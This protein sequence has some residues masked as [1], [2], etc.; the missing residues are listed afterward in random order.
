MTTA[1]I[2]ELE[3]KYLAP[4]YS[5]PPIVLDRGEGAYLYDLEGKRYL[6]FIGGIAVNSLGHSVPEIIAAVAQQTAKLMHV[7]NLYH[8]A[9]HAKLAKLLVD[10]AFPSRVFFC[11][12]GSETIE[13]ALKFSR[14]WANSVGGDAK[15]EIVSFEHSFHG[16]TYGAISATAQPKYHEGF[17]PMLPGMVY[18][19]FNDTAA[20]DAA[21]SEERTAAVVIEPVQGEGGV[22]AAQAEFLRTLRNL[23]DE[24][25]IALIFDEIQCGLCR[26]GKFFAYQHH[27]IEP[28][29]MTLAKPLGGGLPIGALLM[30][31]H[32]ADTLKPGLHG[33]TF[34]ANPVACHV[35][36]AVVSKMINE[37]L[38]ERAATSGEILKTR[39]RQLQNQYGEITEVRG[40]GLLIGVEFGDKVDTIVAACRDKGLLIGSAGE[41]VLRLAPPLI[42]DQR[43]IDEAAN[44]LGAV[45]AE[46]KAVASEK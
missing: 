36:L 35:A 18:L 25:K 13:A 46:R 26:T 2:I 37:N 42:I 23:C 41:K 14:R 3:Q 5:R 19:P 33:S 28:D 4:T 15:Y 40:S 22:N 20:L 44:I 24:R 27:G 21:L 39:L 32:I 17:K 38:A 30:K 16:R 11:N 7:S 29:L 12:S 45:L 6:D 9:P 1:E 8:T 31:Q 10:Q 34:G 43:H